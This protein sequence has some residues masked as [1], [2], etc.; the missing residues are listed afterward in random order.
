MDLIREIPIVNIGYVRGDNHPIKFRFK[1]FTGDI[2]KMFFTVKCEKKFLRLQKTLKNG[3]V[4]KEDG[5]YYIDFVPEDTNN[6]DCDLKMTYDIQIV[7]S[8]LKYTVQKGAFILEEDITTPDCE[9]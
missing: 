1:T 5:Y 7:T 3:I 9:V 8:G 2:E 6:I 4:L